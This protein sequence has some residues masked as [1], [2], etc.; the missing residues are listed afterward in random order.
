MTGLSSREVE[1]R[2]QRGLDNVQVNSSTRTVKEIVKENVFTYF[3][4][5]FTVLGIL[6]VI[7][8]SFKDLSFMLIVL[9]NT[10]IGIAQEIRSKQTLDKLKLLKM[11][12]SH[13]VR[14]GREKEVAVEK[15]VL[16]DIIILRAGSQIPA[17]AQVVEGSVQVNEALITGE[18]DE[19]TKPAGAGLLSGSFVVS[20]ECLARLTA[21]GRDSYI[22]KLTLEATKDKKTEESEMIKS[23]DKMVRVIGIII[24][25]VGA[26][27]LVQEWFVLEGG[28]RDS[29]ISMVAAVLGMIPEGLYMTASIAM[30]ISAMRLARRDVLVQ[31]MK[32]IETLARVDVLCVDKTG[33]ITENEMKVD[34]FQ[35]MDESGDEDRIVRMIGDLVGQQN[36][37]NVTMAAMQNFFTEKSGRMAEM[38]CPFS[39]KYKYCGVSYGQNNFV[40]GAPEF[41]LR[42]SFDRYGDYVNQMSEKGYRVLAFAQV[43]EAPKGQPLSTRAHLLALIFLTNPIRKAAKETFGFFADNGVDIKVI[44]GDNPVTVS[45]VAL[46]A[47]I[48]GAENYIDARQLVNERAIYEAVDRYTVFGRVTPEQKRMF[49][50]ALKRRGKTVGMTG[51]GVNDILALRDADCSVAMASGS[52]AASNAAQLVLMDSD[53]AKMPSVVAEG[54]RVVNN[55][56]KA[57][58]LYLTKN[59]F[60]LFLALFSVINVLS[61]P[62]TPS[63]ITL[64]SMFTIGIPSF[65]VSLEPN[66]SLIKGKFLTNVFKTA[67]PA[68]ITT[69]ISVSS[70][71]IFGEVFEINKECISTSSTMLVALVGFMILAKVLSPASKLHVALIAAMVIGMG[72][73]V[74]FMPEMF[75]ISSISMQ[76]AMLLVVFLIATEAVFRYIY[77]FVGLFANIGSKK[78]RRRKH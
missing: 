37:D 14:D 31:N 25:P 28:F 76:A 46:E 55:I 40:L 47:G 8:G 75:G 59:I 62:L 42:E 72:Y 51:D 5:I 38:I 61:Y 56:Q 2:I 26:V 44:S 69:F 50:K 12:K 20:G 1:D 60:S 39:S 17:D 49:V 64:I 63:Q 7:V 4:L 6:L 30:V 21:V 32:C 73:C 13:V 67:A 22:S 71:V 65:V 68:G 9:A 45:N 29:V 74:L 52:E 58:T 24:I 33:T 48:L 43:G 53:F 19:I 36:K 34:G 16:D 27:L 10:V 77:K 54:R 18:S 78:R 11:P 70:L 57:A 66:K 15:L 3:N 35:I 41:V 23:L